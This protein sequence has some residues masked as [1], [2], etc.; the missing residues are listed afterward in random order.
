MRPVSK[1]QIGSLAAVETFPDV[2]IYKC[3]ETIEHYGG[4]T[5]STSHLQIQPISGIKAQICLKP[6]TVDAWISKKID[7]FEGTKVSVMLKAMSMYPSAVFLDIGS[8][9]GMYTVMMF[10][11]GRQVVAV[12]AMLVNLAYIHQSL[13]FGNTTQFVRLLNNP[14]R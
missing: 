8:N 4:R 10:A 2:E 9:I 7:S 14:V 12:D 11:A 3:K 5:L 1:S 6:L 13:T